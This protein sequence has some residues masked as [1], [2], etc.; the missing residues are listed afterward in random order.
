MKAVAGVCCILILSA[1]GRLPP[2]YYDGQYSGV[3]KKDRCQPA[4]QI[5]AI[6]Y[7]S[8]FRLAVYR[9]R[10]NGSV[11]ADGYLNG[12]AD[13]DYGH[14]TFSGHIARPIFGKLFSGD[15]TDGRCNPYIELSPGMPD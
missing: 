1:C 13:G 6:V 14:V 7:Q 3:T 10:I 4:S 5:S 8:Q 11:D 15:V 12:V 9:Y 2:S